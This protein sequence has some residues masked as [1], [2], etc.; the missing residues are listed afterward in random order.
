M[1]IPAPA[2]TDENIQQQVV[3]EL[4]WDA[5]VQAGAVDP[6][7]RRREAQRAARNLGG[8]RRI[9]NLITVRLHS[10]PMPDYITDRI[11]A[12]LIRSALL[13]TRRITVTAA[14]SRVIL[15]GAVRS[16][17]R[18]QAIARIVWSAQGVTEVENHIT[19]R[20]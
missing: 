18:R 16:W 11:A 7:F 17:A 10:T 1:A 9:T 3:D 5:S 20:P 14:G 12:A 6:D 13:D 19:V 2:N 8:E 15:T 4:K